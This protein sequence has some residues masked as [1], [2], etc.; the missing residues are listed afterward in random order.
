VA[1]AI[2]EIFRTA[3][4]A[5]NL[6]YFNPHSF[7]KTLALYGYKKCFGDFEALKSWSQNMGHAQMLTTLSS[8]GNVPAER[9]AEIL[10]G[11]RADDSKAS[12][13]GGEPD[14]ETIQMVLSHLAKTHRQPA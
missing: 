6:P 10:N 12:G 11:Q 7:R 5:A 1:C 3:F 2:R 4:G 9:Q 8:Y 13:R 14:A